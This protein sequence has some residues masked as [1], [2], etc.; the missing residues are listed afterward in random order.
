MKMLHNLFGTAAS[1]ATALIGSLSGWFILIAL[2]IF[3]VLFSG[4][5]KEDMYTSETVSPSAGCEIEVTAT[6]VLCGWG[7]FENIWLVKK[8]G[9]YLQPWVNDAGVKNL[10]KGQRYKVSYTPVK[11]DDRYKDTII[12][13]AGTPPAEPVKLTCIISASN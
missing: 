11:K 1:V 4:C 7:A 5:S 8:D 13:M 6:P 3:S 9:T 10:V 2:L 12:C